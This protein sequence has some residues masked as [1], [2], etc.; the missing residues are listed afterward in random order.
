MTGLS[1]RGLTLAENVRV[2]PVVEDVSFSAQAGAVTAVLG[3]AGAGKT[4]LLAGIAGLR[5]PLRGAV[6]VNGA[7]VTAV[8][9]EKRGVALLAPGADLG[10][11]R[12]L[13]AALR[14]IAGRKSAGAA[15]D[16]LQ[17]FGLSAA[18]ETRVAALTHGQG[19]AALTAARLAGG[20]D[21]LLVDDAGT[22]LDAE[23]R[24]ALQAWLWGQAADGRTVVI[25]TRDVALA[26]AADALVL[27][28][29]GQV[30]QSGS[31]ASVYAEPRDL[32]AAR[33]TGPLNLLHG[34]VRQKISGGFVWAGGGRKFSQQG[35]GPALGG[36]VALGLRP[37]QIFLAA[38]GAPGNTV[39]GTITRL[40]CLGGRTE[41]W[42]DTAL[43]VLRMHSPG[44][45]MLRQGQVVTLAWDAASP[46][47]LSG[48][49]QP[50]RADHGA[51]AGAVAA[52]VRST[53]HA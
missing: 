42:A 21:V 40:V 6:F 35:A 24:A 4:M 13:A 41:S 20:G 18:A 23:A 9:T 19:F 50:G 39:S 2:R 3:L 51:Q 30:L 17:T 36:D 37:E 1:V 27:L 16:L 32:T 22:G 15:A 34:V 29:Q 38:D 26:L 49:A 52:P 47:S 11:D 43:G 48:D 8:R 44:P 45:A 7:D 33:L 5:K 28:H 31:P 53:A 14:R 12:T 25:A 10:G 46:C